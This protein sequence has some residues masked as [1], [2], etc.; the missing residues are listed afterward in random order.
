MVELTIRLQI[1]AGPTGASQVVWRRGMRRSRH[2]DDPFCPLL[3]VSRVAASDGRRRLEH[4]G[5][6]RLCRVPGSGAYPSAVPDPDDR[7]RP[8]AADAGQLPA[9]AP[10]FSPH[11]QQIA[12]ARLGSGIFTLKIDG[13]GLRRLTSG[14]RDT[15]PVWSPDGKRIAFVRA[16]RALWRLYV[17]SASGTKPRLLAQAPPAGRPT[18]TPDG[19]AILIPASGDLVKVDSRIG[20]D[21][22]LLRND[23]RHSDH[24]DRDAVAQS[25]EDRVR[26]ASRQHRPPRLRGGAV[27]SVRP[28]P[29]QRSEATCRSAY[30]QRHRPRGVVAGRE[31]SGLRGPRGADA[32]C[33]RQQGDDDDPHGHACRHG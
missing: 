4:H 2:K 22:D 11:G 23:T 21:S 17:M 5:L 19:K 3:V 24:A 31:D 20:K 28:L 6:D 13:S 33:D 32:L 25:Q 12:F 16:H 27:P 8:P 7:R 29:G 18:W 10:S 26:R 9:S 30:L 14:K 15:Y 1:C